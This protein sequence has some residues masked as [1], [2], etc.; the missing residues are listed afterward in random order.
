L[1]N[2]NVEIL[3]RLGLIV[4]LDGDEEALFARASRRT[5]RPLLQTKNPREAFS[6]I[7][8][9]RR[10]LYA[11]IADIRLETSELTAEEVAIAILSKLRRLNRKPGSSIPAT[12]S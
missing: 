3:K 12:T 8:Y 1:R 5:D 2:E 4:W 7:F 11:Q 9:A 10:P 6:Q